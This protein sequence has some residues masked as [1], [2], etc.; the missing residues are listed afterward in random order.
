MS[1]K[2]A[3]TERQE[4]DQAGESRAPWCRGTALDSASTTGR[5]QQSADREQR[6]APGAGKR[7]GGLP[8]LTWCGNQGERGD[9][10]AKAVTQKAYGEVK[11]DVKQKL[12]VSCGPWGSALKEVTPRKMYCH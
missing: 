11:T 9:H 6:E 12:S 3:L 2:E 5:D 8:V 10:W 7:R 4:W 1:S